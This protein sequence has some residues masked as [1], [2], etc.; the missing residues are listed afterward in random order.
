MRRVGV[1]ARMPGLRLPWQALFLIP[2][3]IAGLLALLTAR[4]A[5]RLPRHHADLDLPGAALLIAGSVALLFGVI[6]G[7]SHGW[8]SA[9][10]LGAF[11]VAAAL[12]AGFVAHQF[13]TAGPL[14][15]PRL[16]ARPGLRAGTLGV[17]VLFFGLF[18]LFFVNARYLQDVMGL[19]PLLTGLAILPL[20]I[21]M[22][23]LSRLS[24]RFDPRVA[25]PSGLA[26]VVAGLVTLSF[27]GAGTPYLVY[28]VGPTLMGTALATHG[29]SA[30]YL[31]IA[32]VVLAGALLT[33]RWLRAPAARAQAS[34]GSSPR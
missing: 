19:S 6:E 16:F 5:P 21:P 1:V 13:R 28:A 12:L 8:L 18:A 33:L 14:L 29:M 31:V 9:A 15:D 11:A 17:A 24:A 30:G 10:V 4:L 23:V 34:Y 20:T 25:V 7:P 3:P 32:A 2:V 26:L 27:V 22:I